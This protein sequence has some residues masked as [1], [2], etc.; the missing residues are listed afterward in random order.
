[1]KKTLLFLFAAA[2][3][4]GSAMAQKSGSKSAKPATVQQKETEKLKKDGTPDKRYKENK[5]VKSAPVV[6][7]KKDGTP[8]KRYKANKKATQNK[9]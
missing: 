3:L 9:K 8:D 1:M 4:S 6:P 7:T 5:N 2:L